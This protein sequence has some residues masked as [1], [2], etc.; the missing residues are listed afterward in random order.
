MLDRIKRYDMKKPV[1]RQH[2]RW[3]IGI[4]AAPAPILHRNKLTKINMEG[5]KPPYLLLCNHNAFMDFMVA[6]KA[7]FPRRVSYVIAIDGLIGIEWLIR[8]IGGICTRKF[9]SDLTLVRQ[10]TRV[11]KN[12]DIAALYP[13]ARYSLCGTTAVIPLSVAKLAKHLNVPVV[14][15]ICHG[16]HINSPFWNV[17]DRGVKPTTAE[18]TCIATPEEIKEMS[19]EELL[20]KIE[21][22]FVYDDFAWQKENNIKVK[23]KKRAEGLHK[24]LYQCPNCG[25]EYRMSSKGFTLRCENCGK[26]WEMTELGELCAKDGNTEFSHIPDWYEWERLNVRKEVQEGKYSLDCEARV[27]ALPNTWGFIKLGDARLTHNAEGFCLKGHYKK[28]EEDYEVK[29]ATPAIYSCHIEYDY[30]GRGDCIDLNTSTD[31]LYIFPK[32]EDF[33]ITKIALA[34]EELFDHHKAQKEKPATEEKVP[35]DQPAEVETEDRSGE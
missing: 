11:M 33:A 22:A 26:E 20:K 27:E 28:F 17:G 30:K 5:I 25:T 10:M 19:A 29:I 14:T 8:T 12:G 6:T 1:R 34:T 24:V 23:N 16:H 18:M 15:L 35:C 4:L 13:E 2:L 32:G 9:T 7:T 31:T 3:L 21:E